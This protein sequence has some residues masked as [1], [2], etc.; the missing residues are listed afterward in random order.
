MIEREKAEKA[1]TNIMDSY[2]AASLD[3]QKQLA[4]FLEGMVFQMEI[5]KHHNNENMSKWSA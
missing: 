3:E 4:A 5:S 2:H 1:L